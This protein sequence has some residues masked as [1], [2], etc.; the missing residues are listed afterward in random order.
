[1]VVGNVGDSRAILAKRHEDGTTLVVEQ[2][3]VDLKPDVPGTS[4]VCLVLDMCLNRIW[5]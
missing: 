5:F 2:L 1:M 3:T 4:F